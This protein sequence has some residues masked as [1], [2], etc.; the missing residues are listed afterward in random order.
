MA[1]GEIDRDEHL[2]VE[3]FFLIFRLGE[4]ERKRRG[5]EE[6]EFEGARKRREEKEELREKRKR[7]RGRGDRKMPSRGKEGE[8]EQDGE[9]RISNLT[10]GIIPRGFPDHTSQIQI[11]SDVDVLRFQSVIHGGL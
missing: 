2:G 11:R 5:R 7:G 9:V 6:G 10:N 8:Q 4:E 3:R 1:D